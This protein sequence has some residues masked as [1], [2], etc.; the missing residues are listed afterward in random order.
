MA[1]ADVQTMSDDPF[2]AFGNPEQ[3][4]QPMPTA[5][6]NDDPWSN[7]NGAVNNVQSQPVQNGC[8]DPWSAG[9]GASPAVAEQPPAP[10]PS[11]PFAMNGQAAQP[12][13]MAPPAPV[14]NDQFANVNGMNGQAAQPSTMAPAQ[15]DSVAMNGGMNVQ[16]PPVAQPP[17]MAPPAPVPNDPFAMSPANAAPPAMAPPPM[18]QNQAAPVMPSQPPT[19]PFAAMNGTQKEAAP[20]QPPVMPPPTDPWANMQPPA[21]VA[22][23]TMLPAPP[24]MQQTMPMQNP[25]APAMPLQESVPATVV[26]NENAGPP[27]PIGDVSVTGAAMGAPEV[28]A[29]DL[30]MM[31]IQEQPHVSLQP[32]QHTGDVNV[33]VENSNPFEMAQQPVQQMN[34]A[35]P[36][37]QHQTGMVPAPTNPFDLSGQMNNLSMQ[38]NVD[39]GS[40]G[41][42]QAPPMPPNQMPPA[43]PDK[44][45]P[46]PPSQPPSEMP[47]LPNQG[48][49]QA[50]LSPDPFAVYSPGNTALSPQVNDPFGYAFSPITSPIEGQSGNNVTMPAAVPEMPYMN[51][52]DPFASQAQQAVVPSTTANDDPFGVFGGNAAPAPAVNSSDPFGS[53]VNSNDNA[54]VPSNPTTDDPFGIFGAPTTTQ[55]PPS[56]PNSQPPAQDPMDPWAAAGFNEINQSSLLSVTSDDDSETPVELDTNN[57]PK[58][59]DYYEARINA[60][61]LGAMFYTSRDLENTL[62]YHMPTNVIDSMAS[63]PIVAYVAENSAAYNSGIHLG[64]CI[65]SVNGTEVSNPEECAEVI[66]SASRPMNIRGYVMPELEV[67]LAEGKH[68]VKYDK[69]DLG[70]PTTTMEW[71]EKYVVVGGIVAKP[72]VLN[73]YRSKVSFV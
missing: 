26:C 24:T 55:Q 14:S 6:N 50:P 8:N 15:I 7:M 41:M 57:L 36:A 3:Q 65:L 59:G 12:P 67:S 16:V 31:P 23:P 69:K 71:K 46:Q 19:D 29:F 33:Q 17:A 27:S 9:N 2:A 54:M 47:Q 61:S 62:L 58:Q 20:S 73:M 66:R 40:N 1:P 32:Q 49:M 11:D 43:P 21:P 18:Q 72:W 37:S 56:Q 53:S 4:Q 68:M 38:G 51:G 5:Q 42:M 35:M 70:A 22:A 39:Q 44:M 28:P 34:N 64:H 52:T 25:P 30:S 60:R 63:R 13:A 48:M 10:V 45:P